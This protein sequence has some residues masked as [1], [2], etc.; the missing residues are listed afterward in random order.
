MQN[1]E[2]VEAFEAEGDLD[3]RP[4]D[5]LLV[6]LGAL[7]LVGDYLLVEVA[8]IEKLHDDAEWLGRY[9]RELDS[10]KECL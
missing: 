8:V 6:E 2:I 5:G 3:E 4:P 9:Q 1:I 10:M 7:L